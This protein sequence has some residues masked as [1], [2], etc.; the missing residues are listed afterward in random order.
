M[1]LIEIVRYPVKS[2]QGLSLD[3]ACTSHSGLKHD[4]EWLIA[5][6][7]GQFLTARQHPQLLLWSSVADESGLT[8]VAPDKS[9]MR[10]EMPELIYTAQVCVWQDCFDAYYSHSD[11]NSWLSEQLAVKCRVYW[12]GHFSNRT[13]PYAQ[14]SL[15][16][17]DSAPYSLTT[18]A[19]LHHLNKQLTV[20]VS[21]RHFRP[22][23]VIDGHIAYEEDDW[24]R[25]RIGQVE[26]EIFTPYLRSPMI[27]LDPNSAA[28]SP[29]H[30]PFE[31]LLQTRRACFGMGM[32]ALN[33]GCLEVGDEV[34]IL[35]WIPH[36][37]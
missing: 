10:I 11:A 22:N 24:K 7:E 3:Y 14:T 18:Q 12:L 6:P 19:S 27:N 16:F 30:E 23:L 28:D 1:K 37:S 25:I 34:K 26:F 20:P 32:I 4:H 8:L 33:Q 13:L 2:M 17:A 9:C 29:E 35:K 5:T 15:S 21:M 36:S 31:T